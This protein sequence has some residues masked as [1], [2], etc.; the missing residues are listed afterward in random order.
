MIRFI[1]GYD[2][3]PKGRRL[4]EAWNAQELVKKRI[5]KDPT[6]SYD[7]DKRGE[8]SQFWKDYHRARRALVYDRRPR[9]DDG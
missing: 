1:A 5:E 3:P 2:K 7:P 9:P 8:S 6:W 4:L